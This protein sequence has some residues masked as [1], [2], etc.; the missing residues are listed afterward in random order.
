MTSS[1][2]AKGFLLRSYLLH[3][4]AKCSRGLNKDE[5]SAY[6]GGGID[7]PPLPLPPCPLRPPQ[8]LSRRWKGP[9]LR[10]MCC[11]PSPLLCRTNSVA[12]RM[13]SPPAAPIVSNPRL[14][15]WPPF[16]RAGQGR[17]RGYLK[18]L[19]ALCLVHRSPAPFLARP[20]SMR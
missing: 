5:N 3:D 15:R 1:P 11:L 14:R 2:C 13:R 20:R 19:S 12:E 16:G 6:D 17:L 18:P 7:P 9:T 10:I 4:W 8:R